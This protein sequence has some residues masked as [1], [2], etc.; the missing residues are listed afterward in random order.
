MA[1]ALRSAEVPGRTVLRAGLLLPLLIPDFVIAY[2]WLRAY[3]RA[4]FTDDL[5]GWAWASVQGPVGVAVV[6]TVNAVPLVYLIVTVGLAARAE[7][8]LERAARVSGAGGWT[9][10]RTITLPVLKPAMATAAV[11]IF[12][13]TLGAFAIPQVMG[14]PAGF[15]TITT[16]IYADLAL[17]SDPQT[18]VEAITLGGVPRRGDPDHRCARRSGPRCPAE[19]DPRLRPDAVWS[20]PGVAPMSWRR[21]RSASTCC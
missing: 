17:G 21:R 16:R 3:G 19:A 18:F 9:V 7:P 1:L 11:L 8:A 6:L 12:V 13:L 20:I 10:L 4:G 14:T 2:S 15:A 5:L